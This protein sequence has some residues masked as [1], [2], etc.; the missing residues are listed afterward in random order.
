MTLKTIPI[1]ELGREYAT[2]PK[3][4]KLMPPCEILSLTLVPSKNEVTVS[5][6]HPNRFRSLVRAARR[7][8]DCTSMSSM[9]VT[10]E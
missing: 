9:L 5:T 6:K 8:S 7:F 1:P 3:A 4:A 10:N 2:F